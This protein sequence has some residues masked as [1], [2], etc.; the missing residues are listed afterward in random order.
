V[1]QLYDIMV[2]AVKDADVLHYVAAAGVLAH[3]IGDACQPLHVS[4]LHH[5]LPN[6]ESDD[7]V[8]AVYENDMLD[9]F[10]GEVV[11]GVN[12]ALSGYVA[13]GGGGPELVTGADNAAAVVVALME[14]TI[15]ALPPAE[16]LDTFNAHPGAGRTKSMWEAL[17]DR[18]IERL[19]DGAKT[20]AVVWR[21]A[22]QEGGGEDLPMSQMKIQSDKKLQ[23]LYEQKDFAPNE[24][25]KDWDMLPTSLT[26][27]VG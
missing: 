15:A 19:A 7:R 12:N 11:T 24:W 27:A 14:R 4:R 16:I 18:T 8:H 2:A 1:A 23:N 21:S 22:W 6:D 9:Q 3:Y 20:L 13:G 26:P 25:L 17:G 10:A 5:G